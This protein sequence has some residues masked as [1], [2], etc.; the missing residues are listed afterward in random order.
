[1]GGVEDDQVKA[2]PCQD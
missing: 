1:M 2:V